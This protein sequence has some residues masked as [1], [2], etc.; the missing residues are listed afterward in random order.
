MQ[1]SCLFL[2]SSVHAELLCG[3]LCI[4]NRIQLLV[5]EVECNVDRNFDEVQDVEEEAQIEQES[6]G[7]ARRSE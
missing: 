1:A 7:T 2:V 5:A 4:C 6:G 3:S